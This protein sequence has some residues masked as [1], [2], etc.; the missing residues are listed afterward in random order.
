MIFIVFPDT[1]N[2]PVEI[3]EL[4][5]RSFKE[6]LGS[7]PLLKRDEVRLEE[8]ISVLEDTDSIST[9]NSP[10]SAPVAAE[11]L[12]PSRP[13]FLLMLLASNKSLFCRAADA[14]L[15]ESS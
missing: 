11:A 6:V 15:S 2:V 12:M 8:E 10:V 3:G 1:V 9:L 4:R 5:G 14:L 13:E 7:I